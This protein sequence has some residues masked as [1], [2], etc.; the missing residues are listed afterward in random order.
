MSGLSKKLG[1]FYPTYKSANDEVAIEFYRKFEKEIYD[2]NLMERMP[3]DIMYRIFGYLPV[4]EVEMY[5]KS[6]HKGIEQCKWAFDE[7]HLTTRVA[8]DF[9]VWVI[10]SHGNIDMED[11]DSI[12]FRITWK[13]LE[14]LKYKI[15]AILDFFNSKIFQFDL[16]LEE[17]IVDD[18]SEI[19]GNIPFSDLLDVIWTAKVYSVVV[20]PD[21]KYYD[22]S[23]E[24]DDVREAFRM[25]VE[26]PPGSFND[27]KVLK[28][29]I[30]MLLDR[31]QDNVDEV[32]DNYGIPRELANRIKGIK[33]EKDTSKF[34]ENTFY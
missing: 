7:G 1:N 6:N 31:N 32:L 21:S 13:S 17:N 12:I 8:V 10:D 33:P 20:D 3:L 25:D 15:K 26:W 4:E 23:V 5:S 18:A 19:D 27:P 29:Q 11:S 22:A 34:F 30:R 24:L 16:D 9:N 2:R 28:E 14:E